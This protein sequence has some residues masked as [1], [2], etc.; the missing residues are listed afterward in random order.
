MKKERKNWGQ[1][2]AGA[3]AVA[4]VAALC[5]LPSLSAGWHFDDYLQIVNNP[6]LRVSRLSLSSLAGAALSG[7]NRNRP[8]SYLSFALDYFRAGPD[9]RAFHETNLVL[10]LGSALLAWLLLRT[11]FKLPRLAGALPWPRAGALLG[12]LLF[13]VNPVQ[14]QSVTY[15]VQRMNLLASM[16]SLAAML[17]YVLSLAESVSRNRL[18][19]L[20]WPGFALAAALGL[21]GKENAIAI[22]LLV[23]I[24][25]RCLFEGGFGQWMRKRFGLL[26][27]VA[28]VGAVVSFLYL[29]GG[30]LGEGYKFRSFTPGERLLTQPRVV[31]WYVSLWLFP[32]GSRLTLDHEIMTS[33][34]AFT[35]WT[36]LPAILVLA[37]L[38]GLALMRAERYRLLALGWLWFVAG[39][40]LESSVLPLEMAF[41]HRL[42]LPSLGL[43]MIALDLGSRLRLSRRAAAVAACIALLWFAGSY[44]RNRTW[45]D[46][47]TMWKDAVEKAPAKSRPWANLCAGEHV[48]GHYQ[49][50]AVGCLTA[51]RL[52]E[53]NATAWYNLGLS[54]Y[55]LS[56]FAEAEQALTRSSQLEPGWAESRY[57]LGLAQARL[58]KLA[59]AEQSLERAVKLNDQDPVYWYQLGI[60]Q[61]AQGKTDDGKRSLLRARDQAGTGDP[62]LRRDIE[63]ALTMAGVKT[64][65]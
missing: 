29:Q 30:G 65:N 3:A 11:L 5:Y 37:G 33:T 12:A 18:R 45:K 14:T 50:A 35:P 6:G 55:R 44:G 10:H 19:L 46:A 56:R 31:L 57:Q 54:L 38:T 8:L 49:K 1:E 43:V 64:E 34:G 13:A 62:E 32:A 36:T 48:A 40:A 16:F 9:P 15:I 52:D 63:A 20:V 47:E 2:A 21:A 53:K 23:L 7:P 28:A 61:M 24:V 59:E 4:L 41:E 26:L 22:L 42:Y 25:D 17:L 39:L 27:A 58:G 60:I 51:I